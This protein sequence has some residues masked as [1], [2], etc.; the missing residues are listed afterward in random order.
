M[1]KLKV[2]I[3]NGEY[4]SRG[5]VGTYGAR[6]ERYL[7]ECKD[8]CAKQ[9]VENIRLSKEEKQKI[10]S[11]EIQEIISVQYEPGMCNPNKLN[12]FIQKYAQPIV[13][14]AHHIGQLPQFYPMVDGIVL[15]SKEQIPKG[16]D[17]PWDYTVIP[18]PA[19]V[20]PKQDK[21]KLRK[22]YG[23]PEDKVIIGTAG[24]IVGTG[25]EIPNIV[26]NIMPKMNDDEF[27]YCITSFWKGGDFGH[28][29]KTKKK[30]INAGKLNQFRMDTDFVSDEVLN[31][32]MQCCDLLFAWNTME[33][34]SHAG[35]QSGIAADMYGSYTKTIVKDG[36]HY[37]YIGSI[38]GVEI[39]HP[40]VED[41]ASDVLETA[42]NCDLKDIPDP[43]NLSWESKIKDYVEYFQMFVE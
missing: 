5:G 39:G 41:F 10:K 22:K 6:L 20:F 40:K 37:S 11:R 24:F 4:G 14:T 33:H 15:H 18:H 8:V 38:S 9:F 3:Q 29:E 12:G 36:P 35:S 21:K 2:H 23:L 30:V 43:K 17:E 42:R 1:S 27:L 13:I 19:L 26:S 16:V 31:E 28:S 32:K 25:K 7:N 34:G